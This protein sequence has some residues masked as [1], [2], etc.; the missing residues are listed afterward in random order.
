[1]VDSETGAGW[2][3]RFLNWGYALL[4]IIDMRLA[5]AL[6]IA[7]FL[8]AISIDSSGNYAAAADLDAAVQRQTLELTAPPLHAESASPQQQTRRLA[9]ANRLRHSELTH[10]SLTRDHLTRAHF[11]SDFSALR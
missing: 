9:L 6:A 3:Q 4:Q 5:V 11:F 10:A 8:I 7:T 2:R 1:M